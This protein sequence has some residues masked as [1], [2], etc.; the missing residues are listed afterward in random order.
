MEFVC[1][2][3][4]SGIGQG[5][6]WVS[7]GEQYRLNEPH[8]DMLISANRHELCIIM[9]GCL[10]GLA[11]LDEQAAEEEQ[12]AARGQGEEHAEDDMAALEEEAIG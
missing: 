2:S 8:T 9:E 12:E 3:S 10:R 6:V 11:L 4:L 1:T 5:E 7:F